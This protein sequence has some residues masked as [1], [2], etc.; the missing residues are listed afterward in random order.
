M[1]RL[2]VVIGATIF[3]AMGTLHGLLTLRDL[4]TPKAFTPKDASVRH[5]M[6]AAK[7]AFN[8]RVAIWQAWL[9]FNLSHSL[10]LV[11]FGAG[12]L[13]LGWFH[14]E[15]FSGNLVVQALTLLVAGAYF[16]LSV[17]FWFWGPALGSGAALLGFLI[18]AYLCWGA[19]P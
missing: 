19:P 14:F 18:S 3:L 12:L 15:V 6:Q 13:A 10:G 16:V 1:A 4:S 17:Q 11:V 5:A 8:P 7:L 2:L 9:G